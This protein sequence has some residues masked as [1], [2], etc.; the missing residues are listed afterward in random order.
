[1]WFLQIRVDPKHLN[2]LLGISEN[3]GYTA[4][5]VYVPMRRILARWQGLQLLSLQER[6]LHFYNRAY[7]S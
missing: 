2:D 1:M 5:H 6:C 7:L 4:R 3:I